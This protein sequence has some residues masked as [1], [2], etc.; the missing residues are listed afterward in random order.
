[1]LPRIETSDVIRRATQA[2][3][4]YNLKCPEATH[5][6]QTAR[7]EIEITRRVGIIP[8]AITTTFHVLLSE[9]VTNYNRM[10]DVLPL[11]MQD[12]ANPPALLT[13][14]VR[15]AKY[16]RCTDRT[17]RNHVRRLKELG[18]VNTNFR[19]T[20]HSFEL[21]ISTK[22]LYP[23]APS[24]ESQKAPKNA[25]LGPERKIFPDNSTHGESIGT[26]KGNADMLIKQGQSSQGQRGKT[27]SGIQPLNEWVEQQG[28]IKIAPSD[29]A[30]KSEIVAQNDQDRRQKATAML[31]RRMPKMPKGLSPTFTDMLVNFWLY[32]WKV[33]YPTRQFTIEQQEKALVAISAGVYENFQGDW[34]SQQ[35]FDYHLVQMSK[36]DKAG[37]Y[38]DNHP[39]AYRPDPYAV[40]IPGKGYFDAANLKG[41]IGIDAWMKKDSIRHANQRKAYADKQEALTK[42]AETLLRTARRDFE[43][44]RANLKPRKEVERYNELALFQYHNAV[45]S[46]LGKK[47]QE[48]F[49]KQYLEQQAR[50]FEPPRYIKQT[51]HRKAADFQEATVVYV[52]DL[53][54]L[55]GDGEGYYTF[56]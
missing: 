16:A 1:M 52:Q 49:C 25:P 48:A 11:E 5:K 38:Y 39:D 40:H 2:F 15:V 33:L 4:E 44:L 34:N 53:E 56:T 22:Y 36:L 46:G 23:A 26:E 14:S 17:V 20:K 37:R 51:R 47:W 8:E 9:Y 3:D 43:K 13:N 10:R 45:F 41:F 42:R 19:G 12:P 30:T 32:A 18:F 28:Q 27:D 35:W 50:N 31:E 6:R 29:L 24:A 7:G 55:D 21:W 54:M